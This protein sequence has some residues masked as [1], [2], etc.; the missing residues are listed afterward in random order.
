MKKWFIKPVVSSW[1]NTGLMP[2]WG[3][4]VPV[5]LPRRGLIGCHCHQTYTHHRLNLEVHAGNY[6]E[7]LVIKLC[8]SLASSLAGSI[9]RAL[10]HPVVFP[11]ASQTNFA[12]RCWALLSC[13]FQC[14]T[15]NCEEQ[16]DAMGMRHPTCTESIE[17][18]YLTQ[19]EGRRD[20]TWAFIMLIQFSVSA[21]FKK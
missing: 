1:V 3:A 6:P 21:S 13:L 2:N 18:F 17:H 4:A 9:W 12:P 8:K 5:D 11:S 16:S 15:A 19:T 7:S 20:V 10:F 14:V